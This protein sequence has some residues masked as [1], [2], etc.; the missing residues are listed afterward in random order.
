MPRAQTVPE[1]VVRLFRS[2]R[3]ATRHRRLSAPVGG[4]LVCHSR[5]IDLNSQE[6]QR[7]AA[8]AFVNQKLV[9]A[10]LRQ[11]H[12]AFC[13]VASAMTVASAEEVGPADQKRFADVFRKAETWP[14]VM[15][16]YGL[17]ALD[18]LP[19]LLKYWLLSHLQYDG[20]PLALLAQ[21]LRLLDFDVEILSSA[22][23]D[24]DAFREDVLATFSS[25]SDES[26]RFLLINYSRSV[27]GQRMFSG[28]NI[29]PIGG[30]HEKEDKVWVDLPLLWQATHTQVGNGSW[31]GYLRIKKLQNPDNLGD[32]YHKS[33]AATD[34]PP[35][36][37]L[38]VP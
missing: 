10:L 7:L 4:K 33:C 8:E 25:S 30:L 1:Y 20:A 11:E 21:W 18:A 5:L 12:P 32:G 15:A 24:E 38:Y 37:N 27:V 34:A 6:G 17:D 29:V 35:S 28:G 26:R 23:L 9:Q 2:L 19:A 16:C 14:P 36:I 3:D 22:D 13:A 31:R